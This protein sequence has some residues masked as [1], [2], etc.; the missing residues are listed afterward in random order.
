MRAKRQPTAAEVAAAGA[1]AA[2]Q[3]AA[4]ANAEQ[5]RKMKVRGAVIFITHFQLCHAYV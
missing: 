1:Q 5:E 2:A 3:A 4:A